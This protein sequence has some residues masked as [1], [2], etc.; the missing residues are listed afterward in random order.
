MATSQVMQFLVGKSAKGKY[1]AVQGSELSV[2][3]YRGDNGGK[4]F[5]ESIHGLQHIKQIGGKCRGTYVSTRGLASEHSPEDMFA[6]MGNFCYRVTEQ[7]ATKIF[8][9]APG[10]N[11]ISFAETGGPRAMLLA[12][13]GSNLHWYDLATGQAGLVQLPAAIEGDGHIV[14][15][16]HVSVVSGCIVINDVDSGYCYY[17]YKTYP[18]A[19]DTR[20][21]FDLD[22]GE[23]Q[24]EADGITV[25]MKTVSSFEWCFYDD[26]HVQSF[27]NGESSSD[28]VNGL[29]SAGAYLYVFGPKSVEVMTYQGAEYS[30]WSRLYFSA[31]NS[32]GLESP[33]SLCQV[34]TSV[35]FLA[36]GQQRGKCIMRATG[37]TFEPVSESWLDEKLEQEVTD[38][39]YMIP[40]ATSHHQFVVLQLNTL[41][42]TWCFDQATGDWH[43]RTSRDHTSGLEKQWRV[44]GIAYWRE[45]FYAF[46]ND[47]AFMLFDGWT[48]QWKDGVEMPVIRHRQGP[49]FVSDNRD[50]IIEEVALE[51]N[52]GTCPDLEAEPE[53]MLEISEDGGNT[54]SNVISESFGLTGQYGH[55]VRF[56]SL[57]MVR[58]AVLRVTFSEPMDFVL[59]DCD[60]RAAKTRC[61]I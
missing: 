28:C 39:A 38:T 17:S 5:M 61:M 57:G 45:K 40:Y 50:F 32:F 6:V 18:L 8:Q 56:F 42:Q 7:G 23:V 59:T 58:L 54:Y 31:Q 29:I 51:C 22:N 9:V 44:G 14:R 47:G 46:T 24:Y 2:N 41:G 15:P 30:T 3:M 16:I 11:R 53:V 21:V 1:P 49:V 4:Q 25:K 12:A 43:Q 20:Q 52:V 48:E 13:D 36:A 35:F 34:G 27:F 33:N 19:D 60:I 26:Y 55:R 37:T 10:T